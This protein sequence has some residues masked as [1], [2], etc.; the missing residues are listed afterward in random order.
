MNKNIVIQKIK[1]IWLSDLEAKI[2]I[3]CL[4][5]WTS[6]ASSI[7]SNAKVNR[8]S[9]Y[10]VLE[11]LIKR[12]IV[13]SS[14]IK[15]IKHFTA[16]DPRVFGEDVQKKTEDFVSALPFMQ[17]LIKKTDIHPTVRF[18]EWMDWVK[19]AYK[20]TLKS[21]NV[22]YNYANSKNIRDHWPLYDTEYVK[23]RTEKQIFLKGLAPDDS[24]WKWV[25][26]HDSDFF[27]ETKL[28]PEKHFQVENEIN[29]FENKVLIA[30]FDPRPFAIIIE[31]EAVANTQKQIF[32]VFW[33]MV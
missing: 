8:V 3:S 33:N 16:I 28:L 13:S 24:H 31:S 32:E 26:N 25:H 2:Y 19:L 6:P 29:I 1:A 17:T 7:A 14:N 10:D 30:S 27:R 11:K 22:I 23:K 4:E 20:E 21:N 18:F 15:W 5:I 12:W 9:A